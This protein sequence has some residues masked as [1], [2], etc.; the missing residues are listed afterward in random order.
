MRFPGVIPAVV[1]P[2]DE[3]GRVDVAALAT[4]AEWLLD[5]GCT[6]LVGAGIMGEAQSLSAAER[7]LVI[8]TLVE[9]AGSRVSV[10]AAVSSNTPATSIG[11][12]ADAAAAGAETLVALPPLGYG[13]DAREIKAFYR[14]VTESTGLPL[15]V[16]NHPLATGIDMPPAL[17]G[18]L[19]EIELVVA[20]AESSGDARRITQLVN[21][22]ELEVLVGGD[23][24][25]LE[26]LCAGASGWISGAAN[27]TP[28]DC[29]EL[30]EL[31][32][33][34]R[35]EEAREIYARILP[36]CRFSRQPKLVQLYKAAID[37][38]GRRGGHS[39][40]PRLELTAAERLEVEEALRALGVEVPGPIR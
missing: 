27:V 4:N 16:H 31:C 22:T 30:L 35:L 20:V 23:D 7:R 12:A 17:I 26:A 19:A 9:V 5:A 15:M 8:E 40:P 11:Y 36:L 6:G 24:C 29:V 10:T 37:M 32:D 28:R 21:D 3:S 25:A 39:R 2:F 1:T 34:C 14:T 33:S 38:V 13:C 18:S